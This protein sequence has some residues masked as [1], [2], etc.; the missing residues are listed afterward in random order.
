M[1]CCG[2]FAGGPPS[3]L[4]K[5]SPGQE[6][7]FFFDASGFFTGTFQGFQGNQAV[8]RMGASIIRVV[9]RNIIAITT[10]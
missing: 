6:V 5:L 4:F 2:P 7:R 10:P 3:V 8:F 1:R 9:L